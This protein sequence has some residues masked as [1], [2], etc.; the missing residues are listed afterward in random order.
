MV[1]AAR[2]KGR[3]KAGGDPRATNWL[4]GRELVYGLMSKYFI[5]TGPCS[6]WK[7]MNLDLHN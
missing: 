5:W 4:N 1:E 6:N 2:W 3:L 7:R